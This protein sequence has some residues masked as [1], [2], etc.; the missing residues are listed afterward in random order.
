MP[1]YTT[2]VG[3]FPLTNTP[4]HMEQAFRGE[5]EAGITHPCYPQLV[6]MTAQF[7]A[8]LAEVTGAFELRENGYYLL[9]D[10]SL[11]ETPIALEYGQFVV[12]FLAQNPDLAQQIQ[13][14]KACLTGPFTL[15]GDVLLE[16]T[17]LGAGIRKQ[18]FSEPRAIMVD[19][20]VEKFAQLLQSVGNAYSDMGF[21]IISMDEP[22]LNLMVGR[23]MY[24]FHSKDFILEQLDKALAGIAQWPSVHVCGH[25]APLLR[26]LLLESRAKILDHEFTTEEANW[27]VYTR[28]D[29][30]SHDKFLAVGVVSSKV[31]PD[32][33]LTDP[34]DYVESVSDIQ[35]RMERAI[36]LFGPERVIF[37]PDC[38]LGGL[39]GT[40][41]EDFAFAIAMG[42]LRNI[43][44]ALQNVK[45]NIGIE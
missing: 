34:L 10:F 17:D 24:I 37:K 7:L 18:I 38:G 1:I 29:L 15:S 36:E 8:P 16:E 13:G 11:P 20:M 21:Q 41:P 3:S 19:W 44:E 4:E 25:L 23:K 43:T 30:E 42:K 2:V 31:V 28:A 40:F 45:K 27:D 32:P 26:D 6:P 5:I 12:D 14:T 22:T 39:K 9:Q 35:S 33:A